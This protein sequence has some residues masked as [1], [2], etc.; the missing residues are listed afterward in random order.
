LRELGKEFSSQIFN[1]DTLS[2]DINN[3]ITRKC[4]SD[5][6]NAVRKMAWLVAQYHNNL[7]EGFAPNFDGAS[8]NVTKFSK[9]VRK[10]LKGA[11]VIADA[12]LNKDKNLFARYAGKKYIIF[13]EDMNSGATLAMLGDALMDYGIKEQDITCLVNG[14]SSGGF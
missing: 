13:D 14:F 4:M 2:N 7:L 1:V 9:N 3:I 5:F 6:T 11:F 10:Y 12:Q 8:F